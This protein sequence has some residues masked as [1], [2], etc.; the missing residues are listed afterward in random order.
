MLF[1]TRWLRLIGP[2]RFSLPKVV[3][4]AV[5]LVKT[6]FHCS[7]TLG[8][9]KET[10]T[11]SN[12]TTY[13]QGRVNNNR[14]SALEWQGLFLTLKD[15]PK[16][17]FINRYRSRS[18]NTQFLSYTHR[19]TTNPMLVTSRQRITRFFYQQNLKTKMRPLQS[20]VL[21]VSL[22]LNCHQELIG[23]ARSRSAEPLTKNVCMMPRS[24]TEQSA[25]PNINAFSSKL[26]FSFVFIYALSGSNAHMFV[27]S[28]GMRKDYSVHR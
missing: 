19:P 23:T 14:K 20:V 18:L 26:I 7:F 10:E 21:N 4:T 5:A 17:L 27:M 1:L 28:V 3:V 2:L 15:K 6:F 9:D 16:S 12:Y 24:V 8:T 11:L 22:V 13:R 25:C